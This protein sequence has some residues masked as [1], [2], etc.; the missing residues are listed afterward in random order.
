MTVQAVCPSCEHDVS[1]PFYELPAV[2]TNSCLLITDRNAALDFPVAPLRLCMCRGCGF[3]FNAAWE[4][5]RTNYSEHYEGTQGFSQTFN[6]FE[7]R[8][9]RDLIARHG[10]R[11]KSVVEIG[12][13]KGKFL[14]LL[15]GLGNN[16]GLGYDPSFVPIRHDPAGGRVQFIRE[17]FDEQTGPLACDFLCCNMTFEHIH[18]VGDF[19]RVIR[20]ALGTQEDT[21]VFFQVPDAN[22]ILLDVAFWDIYYEHCSYF[23]AHSLSSVFERFGFG[24]DRVWADYDGQ[25]LMIEGRPIRKRTTASTI[26]RG[27]TEVERQVE[28]FTRNV[29]TAVAAWRDR[30]AAGR[31]AGKRIVLWG[32]G[33]KAV[34]FLTTL[35]V[36][37][38][39]TAVV[40][41]NP[42]RQ[43]SFMPTTGHPIIAPQDVP[44]IAPDL[45]IVMNPV[46]RD[47]I[48]RALQAL[49]CQPK[50]LT[51]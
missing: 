28:K 47:E 23:T 1:A 21:R 20:R 12:C 45:V 7:E 34:S 33:S 24:V 11:G 36:K 16:T 41:I 38:E 10:L 31:A 27:L 5:T 14:S 17:F 29:A 46:Y 26:C 9:V 2:P 39:V 13:G 35:N 42:F 37:D 18:K 43:G 50:I 19:L 4:P 15:C 6:A 3:I 51:V 32:S 25:Y 48:G 22:R 30:L 8:L 40:D 49:G 44:T